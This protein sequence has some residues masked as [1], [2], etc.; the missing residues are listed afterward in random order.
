MMFSLFQKMNY[1]KNL[2]LFL[3]RLNTTKETLFSRKYLFYTN[4]TISITLSG[5]GDVLE[6]HYEILKVLS[7]LFL[8]S[9]FQRPEN[10][11]NK[12]IVETFFFDTFP[13]TLD[14]FQIENKLN[15]K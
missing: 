2:S 8:F 14:K 5:V 1:S 11:L 15:Q 7:F 13:K 3:S 10:C 6:Q 4:V 9:H 12:S